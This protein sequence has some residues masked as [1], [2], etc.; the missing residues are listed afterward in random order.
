[1][2]RYDDT[3]VDRFLEPLDTA[4]VSYGKAAIV[5]GYSASR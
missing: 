5:G 3:F 4:P 1:M 2:A